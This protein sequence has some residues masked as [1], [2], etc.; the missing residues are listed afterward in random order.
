MSL[1]ATD[2]NAARQGPCRRDSVTPSCQGRP[3]SAYAPS[4]SKA[5][6]WRAPVGRR[7]RL[8][9]RPGE[10]GHDRPAP[11]STPRRL[12][13]PAAQL[14]GRGAGLA[15]VPR[16]GRARW[17]PG[18]GHGS[19]QDPDRPR[20]SARHRRSTGTPRLVIAPPAVRG[21]LGGRGRTLHPGLRVLSTTAPP[22]RRPTSST[23]CAG[24]DMVSRP[25]P[26][27]SATS[28]TSSGGRLA[29]ARRSTRRRRSRT[30]PS[31]S[32][33]AL[34]RIPA[35]RRLALTGTPVENG[36]GDLWSILDFTNPGLV[37]PRPAF[38]ERLSRTGEGRGGAETALRALNGLLVFRRTKSEP[39]DRR[40]A[41]GQDRPARPLRDDTG[42]DRP[43]PGRRR[44][45]SSPAE[46]ADAAGRPQGPGAGRHHRPE[47]DLQPP[48]RL[49]AT[50]TRRLDRPLGQ[51]GRLEEIVDAVFAAGERILV[52]THFAHW[53]EQLATHLTERSP[54]SRRLLSRRPARGA[55]ATAWS[56]SS[57]TAPGR[58]P[59]CCR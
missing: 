34:R 3:S 28:T 20:P 13:R 31:E 58:A 47:A 32:A 19:G 12:R 6:R 7:Q 33:Q 54:A 21:Q 38:I 29:P 49:P 9:R 23:P 44:P 48:L 25:T 35:R 22:G 2:L 46:L 24:A 52:F 15:G 40:R 41:A 11:P 55:V 37:G 30:L 8:G 56:R 39:L 1:D 51:A 18:P 43:L 42:A 50:T 36:L 5:T 27:P 53:G 16:P 57:R 59:W 45:P 17:L 4:A 26:P 10:A 14:S